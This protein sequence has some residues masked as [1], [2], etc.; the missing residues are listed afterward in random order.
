MVKAH[1]AEKLLVT[2]APAAEIFAEDPLRML[3]A[4]RFISQL[5]VRAGS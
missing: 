3:R 1:L 5:G 2:P 4:A